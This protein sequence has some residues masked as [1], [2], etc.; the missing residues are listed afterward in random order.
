MWWRG[1][2]KGRSIVDKRSWSIVF[3]LSM[4]A[5]MATA[6]SATPVYSSLEGSDHPKLT[7]ESCLVQG[8]DVFRLR[9]VNWSVAG[10]W[11]LKL[12][13]GS[14]IISLGELEA[15]EQVG[16]LDWTA[17]ITTTTEGTWKKQFLED[18]EWVNRN[19]AHSLSV[20]TFTENGWFCPPGPTYDL[21]D[22]VWYDT[23]QDGVQDGGE[24]GVEGIT[25]LLYDDS[26]CSTTYTYS[27]TTGL[28]GGY[29]FT[30]V[31]TG[32]HCLEFLDIPD[33][34]QI[35]LQDQG[36]DDTVDTD[37]DQSTARI[38]SIDLQADDLDQD[39]GLY[40]DGSIGDRLWCDYDGNSLYDPGEGLD[41]IS[42][43]LLEDSNCDRSGGTLL[44]T[45]E[46]GSEGDYAFTDL[47][48][49]PRGAA[50]EVC[51]VVAVD[52]T[53]ADLGKCSLPVGPVSLGLTLTADE[54]DNQAIDFSFRDQAGYPGPFRSFCPVVFAA[55]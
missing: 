21:G 52:T 37:A 25:I 6:A 42:V 47:N 13:N 1:S 9:A 24:P 50:D 26:T 14:E 31:T 17:T 4:A 33:G 15:G 32:T 3:I 30:D 48:T 40:V 18:D 23:N 11:R 10:E 29:L 45:V 49:G 12:H 54:F 7:V 39:L 16:A 46:T 8:T 43:S 34:W 53:D 55:H 51:Y 36:G 19:G 35:S 22:R 27:R 41:N 28:D 2:S 44:G 20:Q 5:V 38:E